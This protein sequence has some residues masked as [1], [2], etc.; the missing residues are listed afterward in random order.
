MLKT[1]LRIRFASL[2][3]SLMSSGSKPGKPV[4]KG[5]YALIIFVLGYAF[6]AV[7]GLFFMTFSLLSEA[8]HDTG[9]GWLYFAF[10]ALLTLGLMVIGSVFAAKTQLYEAKD[11]ELLLSM[12]VPPRTILLSRMALLLGIDY[13]MELLTAIPAGVCWFTRYPDA[14][15]LLS[16]L[17][18][19]LVLPLL[20][21]AVT[22]FLAWI[23]SAATSRMRRKNL[24][25]VVLTIVF[26]LAYM[27][28]V[29]RMSSGIE[30]LAAH[31]A[32]LAGTFGSVAPLVWLGRACAEGD[33]VGLLLGVIVCL[34][35]FVF[36]VYLLSLTFLRIALSKGSARK[37]RVKTGTDRVRT[38]SAA[39]LRNEFGR[40]GTSTT[41]LL[42]GAFGAIILVIVGVLLLVKRDLL[43]PVLEHMPALG[44]FLPLIL[45]MGAALT[46]GFVSV[47]CCS[48]SMEGRSLWILRSLPV[49]ERNVL[50]SKS[51]LHSLVFLPAL[52]VGEIGILTAIRPDVLSA[53]LFP[54][55]TAAFVFYF[56]DLGV[57]INLRHPLLD[58]VSEA[59]AVKSSTSTLLSMLAGM[60]VPI[61]V[62]GLSVV[63]IVLGAP[64]FVSG[65]VWLVLMSCLAFYK[66][67]RLLRLGPELW[68]AI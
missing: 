3:H 60:T 53:I 61:V 24:F 22:A 14:A 15:G 51:R 23:I 1:L 16:F 57:L 65:C 33:A 64:S 27:Y 62:A 40:F 9:L 11:N 35:P 38:L 5:R 28:G 25:T 52:A 6:L 44:Q 34:I 36:A 63:P 19:C 67:R 13:F 54:L 12:P 17:L 41:W 39:L 50:L 42:N 48:I 47:S 29:N 31:G 55:G 10:F 49:L 4:K 8:Y 45:H 18:F 2:L 58:W 20:A 46:C 26:L 32:E 66:R 59:Q 7:G 56:A 30:Y 21:L 68:R 37:N 43:S